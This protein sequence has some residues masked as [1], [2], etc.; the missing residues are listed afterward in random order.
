MQ[1]KKRETKSKMFELCFA[2][3]SSKKKVP[4]VLEIAK[5]K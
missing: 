2:T 3:K 5:K 1:K 4:T